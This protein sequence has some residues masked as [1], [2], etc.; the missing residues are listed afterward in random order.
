M[1]LIPLIMLLLLTATASMAQSDPERP[2]VY[3]WDLP[4]GSVLGYDRHELNMH[5]MVAFD[6][7]LAGSPY[8]AAQQTKQAIQTQ[9]NADVSDRDHICIMLGNFGCWREAPLP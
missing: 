9:I 5:K 8:E 2:A 6:I 3:L 1:K 4:A 7:S